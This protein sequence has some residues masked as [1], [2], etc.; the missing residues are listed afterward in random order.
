MSP[1]RVSGSLSTAVAVETPNFPRWPRR[2]GYRWI[3]RRALLA[4]WVVSHAEVLAVGG[5]A[6]GLFALY[7]WAS[8]YWLDV[9][10]EGYFVYLS[11]RVLAGDLPYRDFDTYYTPG[12]F[13]TYAATLHLFGLSVIPIRILMAGVRTLWAVLLYQLTRRVAPPPFAVLPFLVVAVVDALPILPEPHPAWFAMLATLMALGAVLRHQDGAGR[14][15]LIAAGAAAGAAFAFKQNVGAFAALAV[16]G[17]VVFREHRQTG[18]SVRTLQAMFA[19]GLGMAATGLLWPALSP[20]VVVVLGLPLLATLGLLVWTTWLGTHPN[21]WFTGLAD[22]TGEGLMAGAAFLGVTLCWL[23]P[24][25]LALGVNTVPW[26]LFVGVVNQGALDVLLSLPP[27]ATRS[28]LL[29]ALWLPLA[30]TA[31]QSCQPSPIGPLTWQ[32]L[33]RRVVGS[34]L[35]TG[36]RFWTA[37]LGGTLVSILV[38]VLPTAAPPSASVQEVDAAPWLSLLVAELGSLFLYLPSL[39]AWAGLTMLGA[40]AWK[41]WPIRPLVW[42]LLFGTVSLLALY[43][44]VDIAHAMFAGPPLLIVGAWA[45]ARAHRALAGQA[46]WLGRSAAFMALLVL[47]AAAVLPHVAWR[48]VTLADADPRATT[49]PPYVP[50]GL[51]RAP[52]R[53]PENFAASI[54]GAVRFVQA[55]TPPGASFFAYPVDPLFN[56]LAERPNPTRFN[57]FM[58]GA[59]TP[60][61]L[62]AVIV[63]LERARPRYILWDHGGVVAFDAERTNRPLHEYIWTC[64]QQV[65][66]FPPYLILERACP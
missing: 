38:L 44:R 53:L 30:L 6:T 15:W 2:G 60:A 23:V 10:D 63:D 48:A 62:D 65:A 41:Q 61:D 8:R 25:T 56:F 33:V 28:V 46:G 24:L 12:I 13:Y 40:V 43:P 4:R 29:A 35:R 45:L 57:H 58:A 7:V 11:S 39:G 36:R 51:D 20:L 34:W 32:T 66:N 3:S 22:L 16:G 27:A 31:L 42:Y 37:L 59:L 49:P 52:V 19:L 54:G 64:Y 18:Y 47:P 5:A 55:G 21:D 50:L 14:R 26:W 9:M 1:A 17:Y